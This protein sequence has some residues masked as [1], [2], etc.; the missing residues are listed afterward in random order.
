MQ[1]ICPPPIGNR[2]EYDNTMKAF[3]RPMSM[4]ALRLI[5][6]P[7]R[8]RAK[9]S[10]GKMKAGN[11]KKR[12]F[13]NGYDDDDDED[14]DADNEDEVEGGT[15]NDKL[16]KAVESDNSPTDTAALFEHDDFYHAVCDNVNEVSY[17]ELSSPHRPGYWTLDTASTVDLSEIDLFDKDDLESAPR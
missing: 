7:I 1:I 12:R 5:I 15:H 16:D 14:S 2:R 11:K 3:F 4:E 6:R 10:A 17:N 13:Y 9:R 8:T